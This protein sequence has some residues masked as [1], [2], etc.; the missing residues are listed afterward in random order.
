MLTTVT[1]PQKVPLNLFQYVSHRS[2]NWEKRQEISRKIR[3]GGLNQGDF[4]T[5]TGINGT[6][7]FKMLSNLC[8][9]IIDCCVFEILLV[10]RKMRTEG[11]SLDEYF[12]PSYL[13]ILGA[14]WKSPLLKTKKNS[15]DS[16]TSNEVACRE[17]M[18]CFRA[19]WFCIL[20]DT[21]NMFCFLCSSAMH[22]CLFCM[23]LLDLYML[24]SVFW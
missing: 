2:W 19:V 22:I 6:T 1:A 8:S 16:T 14:K 10:I 9:F 12:L 17:T 20:S 23:E 7:I 4:S 15:R 24:Y 11:L 21:T 5:L 18:E 13:F 3:W